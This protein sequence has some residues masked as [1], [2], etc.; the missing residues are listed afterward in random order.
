[1]SPIKPLHVISLE[2]NIK[3]D[4]RMNFDSPYVYLKGDNGSGKSAILQ[5]IT[6]A[7][8][9]SASDLGFRSGG[10]R[11]EA[12]LREL[13]PSKADQLYAI[14]GLSDGTEARWELGP[15]GKPNWRQPLKGAVDLYTEIDKVLSGSFDTIIPAL[16]SWYATSE[17]I[18][19]VKIKAGPDVVEEVRAQLN[20]IPGTVADKYLGTLEAVKGFR[21]EAKTERKALLTALPHALH[22]DVLQ[23]SIN[24]HDARIKLLDTVIETLMRKFYGVVVNGRSTIVDHVNGFMAAGK[25]FGLRLAPDVCVPG[26]IDGSN[27]IMPCA[28]G[29]EWALLVAAMAGSLASLHPSKLSLIIMPDRALDD[30][31][32]RAAQHHLKTAPANVFIQSPYAPRGRPVVGWDVH[33]LA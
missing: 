11:G 3:R 2:T 27:R 25:S 20:A 24:A 21:N 29:A 7:L 31:S 15:E 10:Y 8:T 14:V 33:Q 1:M 13:L 19:A 23:S 12:I 22:P 6:L 32:L 4:V 16:V 28:S 17:D 26:L 18:G 5:A 30:R 9:G